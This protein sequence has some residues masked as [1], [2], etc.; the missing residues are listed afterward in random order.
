MEGIAALNAVTETLYERIDMMTLD[1]VGLLRR[2]L[3]RCMLRVADT[4]ER[5]P[6][7]SEYWR[8]K[9]ELNVM[10]HGRL[11]S[12]GGA[13]DDRRRTMHHINAR[14]ISSGH[15]NEVVCQA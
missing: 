4:Q 10:L 11:G 5:E 14:L 7:S 13:D 3:F 8:Q 1:E 12:R 15:Q 9:I 2:R 6:L